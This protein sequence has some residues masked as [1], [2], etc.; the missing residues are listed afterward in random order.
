MRKG[1]ANI[2]WK[3]T[4]VCM[5][6]HCKCGCDSHIDGDFVY[7]IE[8]PECGQIY[9]THSEVK[10]TE[11]EDNNNLDFDTHIGEE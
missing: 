7:Y 4:D 5:D 2:Q 10:L 9:K 3:G 1:T 11:V 8:C 6:L